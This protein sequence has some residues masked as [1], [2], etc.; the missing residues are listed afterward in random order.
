MAQTLGIIDVSWK[1]ARLDIEKGGTLRLGGFKQNVVTTS[2]RAHHAREYEASEVKVTKVFRR[3]ESVG[4]V[5]TLGEG[6]LIVLCDTGQSYVFAD[7]VI[8]N[9]PMMTAGE[10][11]KQEITWSASEPEELVNG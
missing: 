1:G 6:E 10:G 4:D 5:F 8:N 11:G 9:R 3:G 2:R 7:A